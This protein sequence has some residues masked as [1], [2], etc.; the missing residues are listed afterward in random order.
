MVLWYICSNA[1]VQENFEDVHL[2]NECPVYFTRRV[3]ACD[4]P[5]SIRENDVLIDY[6]YNKQYYEKMKE[7]LVA[8]GEQSTDKYLTLLSILQ[9]YDDFPDGQSCKIV[10]NGWRQIIGNNESALLGTKHIGE[11]GNPSQW[12][13][14]VK[15]YDG[16]DLDANSGW[17][18]E[19]S[20]ATYKQGGTDYIRGTFPDFGKDTVQKIY[21]TSK[22]SDP[23]RPSFTGLRI[24]PS[25]GSV[26]FLYN[27]QPTIILDDS[28]LQIFM[29]KGLCEESIDD[30]GGLYEALQLVPK[31]TTLPVI[32]IDKDL[33]GKEF[34]NYDMQGRT[35]QV[36]LTF[37]TP[38]VVKIVSKNKT[39]EHLLGNTTTLTNTLTQL[40]NLKKE[41]LKEFYEKNP[42]NS[43]RKQVLTYIENRIKQ[44]NDEIKKFEERIKRINRKNK[45]LGALA[46]AGP[47]LGGIGAAIGTAI[48]RKQVSRLRKRIL[49]RR[50]E[51]F[52][53]QN[54]FSDAN[55]CSNPPENIKRMFG[56][57]K[58][59]TKKKKKRNARFNSYKILCDSN[60][61]LTKT[62][63]LCSPANQ[64][65]PLNVKIMT[66][67]YNEVKPIEEE[68]ARIDEKTN[69]INK[70]LEGIKRAYVYALQANL[71]NKLRMT[72]PPYE[73]LSY[74]GKFYVPL[75]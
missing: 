19:S 13:F 58:K 56:F 11:R 29:N 22:A 18:V 44:L 4:M 62:S 3:Q 35:L 7:Q 8:K 48:L 1:R 37:A 38:I 30:T 65:C 68:M 70:H 45:K 49:N 57:G 67:L 21:C 43:T 72:N 23:P 41:K 2:R 39:L 66:P 47:V 5:G 15:P 73:A 20:G 10:P 71:T 25:S 36:G 53:L 12:A 64:T 17:V 60:H 52:W 75:V 33:C 31:T 74:D 63:N 40:L 55:V 46:A 69:E 26:E 24:E 27:M 16:K 51:L 54:D 9:D 14:C 50:K 61:L 42:T 6:R 59:N 34:I 28:I 32:R